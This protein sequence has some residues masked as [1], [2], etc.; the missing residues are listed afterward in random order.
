MQPAKKAKAHERPA[1]SQAPA[2]PPLCHYYTNTRTL[3]ER[4][5]CK[6]VYTEREAAQVRDKT[7]EGS[8][9]AASRRS[10]PAVGIRRECCSPS[11]HFYPY[12]WTRELFFHGH[13]FPAFDNFGPR[14]AGHKTMTVNKHPHTLSLF[15]LPS[16]RLSLSPSRCL[17]SFRRA[18]A[19]TLV[20]A[21]RA[22]RPLS[23]KSCR[24][25]FS[26]S[27]R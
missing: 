18:L 11:I 23:E 16:L 21:A 9:S 7:S 17:P 1:P 20:A 6:L 3:P 22:D 19:P 2:C 25:F 12:I 8:R 10:A 14:V 5:K 13:V 26:W 15:C 27:L 4:R 24:C